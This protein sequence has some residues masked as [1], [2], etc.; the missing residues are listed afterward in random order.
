MLDGGGEFAG[1]ADETGKLQELGAQGGRDLAV[2]VNHHA[3][4]A[5]QPAD[6]AGGNDAGHTRDGRRTGVAQKLVYQALG[7]IGLAEQCQGGA[8]AA[9][10]VREIVR[11]ALSET[12]TRRS[13]P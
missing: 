12:I 8:A 11:Q 4:G 13:Q 2:V 6:A 7:A 10:M 9:G 5:C 1:H 3:V